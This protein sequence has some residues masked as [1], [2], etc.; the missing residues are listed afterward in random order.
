LK[1]ILEGASLGKI[2]GIK[3]ISV[4]GGVPFWRPFLT[5][6]KKEIMGWMTAHDLDW[7]EDSTNYDPKYLRA[8]M[9]Q[10]LI[11]WLSKE[12][13]KNVTAPLCRLS[14]ELEEVEEYLKKKI[15][16]YYPQ[17]TKQE[18]SICYDFTKAVP[19][20]L[21]E[22]KVLVKLICEAES[23]RVSRAQLNDVVRLLNESQ[24]NKWVE[25]GDGRITVDRR[26]LIFS[27]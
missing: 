15:A 5:V 7:L 4:K 16:P 13:G 27:S 11:P 20:D 25:S 2:P 8:R 10:N 9:R 18:S 17:R 26:R 3:T 23:F 14:A 6:P 21:L 22:W 24:G 19:S 1:R 12:F